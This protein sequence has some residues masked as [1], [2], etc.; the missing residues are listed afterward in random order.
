VKARLRPPW[1]DEGDDPDYRFTLA[2]ERTFLAWVR[3]ALSLMAASVAVVQ[4]LPPFRVAGARSILGVLLALIGVGTALFAYVRW[5]ANE[6]AMRMSRR[7]AYSVALPLLSAA[8]GLTGLVI[9]AL[10]IVERK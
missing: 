9:L 8:L 3:T 2:N 10:V 5:A 4:L 7:I 1:Q 6:Q